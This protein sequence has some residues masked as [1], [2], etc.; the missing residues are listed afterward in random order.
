[1][2]PLQSPAY[3]P[4]GFIHAVD[5]SLPGGLYQSRIGGL[6]TARHTR[7]RPVQPAAA[8]LQPKT[9]GKDLTRMAQ[10]QSHLLVQDG[11]QGQRLRPQL[12]VTDSHRI[13]GLQAM[14]SLH[15]PVAIAAAAYCDSETPN[16]G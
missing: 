9:I 6:R 2:Q 8:D 13:G 15:A 10:R 14:T 11:C 4:A 5:G 1:M 3:F 7:Q 12:H 16:D